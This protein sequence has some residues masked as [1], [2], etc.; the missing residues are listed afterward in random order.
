MCVHCGVIGCSRYRNGHAKKHFEEKSCHPVCMDCSDF[1][2]FC[3]VCDEFVIND[4]RSQD[5]QQLRSRLQ[6]LHGESENVSVNEGTAL[7]T[8]RSRSRVEVKSISDDVSQR[9]RTSST[10]SMA[11]PSIKKS[12]SSKSSQVKGSSMTDKKRSRQ[13]Q[14]QTNVAGLRNLGNTCFMN[15]VLQSLSN[16]Q[17]FSGYFKELPSLEQKVV[18]KNSTNNTISLISSKKTSDSGIYGGGE[19]KPVSIYSTWSGREVVIKDSY[20][21]SN[22]GNS[23]S[24]NDDSEKTLLAEELRKT[25]LLL[26]G[27]SKAAISPESLFQVIWKVVPRYRGYQQQDA[28]EFLRYML[29]RL[30]SELLSI[31]PL[32]TSKRIQLKQEKRPHIAFG[33]ST[34]VTGIFGGILQN[35]V[36]C[37]AC[38][39]KSIKHDPFLDLSLDLPDDTASTKST[40]S[41]GNSNDTTASSSVPEKCH[42]LDCLSSFIRLEELEE[43]ELYLC[44]NC[45]KKQR[46]TKR[47][48]IRRLPNVLCLHL[49][50]FRWNNYFRTKLDTFVEYPLRGLDMSQYVLSNKVS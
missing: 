13:I 21:S 10:P 32:V 37:L 50:R 49:K 35:E 29:D 46:S 44:P 6:S 47:F 23:N 17:Q 2:V 1:S 26:W 5:L 40:D 8:T 20:N 39:N 18:R 41:G 11:S 38:S 31:L 34:I 22:F 15:A 36:T 33:K 14:C 3:Y 42:L 48:W 45:K 9:K 4:T 7:K 24:L 16:I 28:H 19:T 30:H 25:L 12:R 27:G 43:T